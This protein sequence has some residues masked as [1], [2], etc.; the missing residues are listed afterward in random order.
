MKAVFILGPSCSGKSTLIQ[1]NFTIKNIINVDDEY[2]KLLIKNKI[3][4][5]VGSFT[6]DQL[7]LAGSLMQQAIKITNEK[8]EQLIN[9]KQDVIFDTVGSSYKRIKEKVN[10]LEA[11]GYKILIIFL[12]ID[13]KESLIRNNKR[14]RRLITSS[15]LNSW[16]KSVGNISDFYKNFNNYFYI[17]RLDNNNHA[18]NPRVIYNEFPNP[19][20]KLKSKEDLFKSEQDK[21]KI[22]QEI[23]KL[24]RIFKN[25]VFDSI[26]K[27]KIKIDEFNRK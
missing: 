8:E 21:I 25:Y 13:P 7:S 18:F 2:E 22:N 27:V 24:S 6:P 11:I 3:G 9:K 12:Y 4:T 10:K 15:V 16:V 20:G 1:N 19:V 26:F 5:N 14:E 23:E 17:I